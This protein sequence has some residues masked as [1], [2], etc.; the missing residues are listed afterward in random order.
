MFKW[1]WLALAKKK[2]FTKPLKN[3]ILNHGPPECPNYAW[4]AIRQENIETS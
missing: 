4:Q 2:S 1:G 3:D